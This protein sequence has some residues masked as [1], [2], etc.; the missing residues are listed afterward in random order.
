MSI[1]KEYI[2][3]GDRYQLKKRN[4]KMLDSTDLFV[5]PLCA[6]YLAQELGAVKQI[7][8]YIVTRSWQYEYGLTL[9]SCSCVSTFLTSLFKAR[10]LIRLS[11]IGKL[12]TL[13]I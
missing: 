1:G 11:C 3:G 5:W 10:L 13:D 7:V 12:S 2:T 8:F 4:Y 9:V 6:R